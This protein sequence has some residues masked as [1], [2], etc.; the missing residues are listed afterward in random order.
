M[1]TLKTIISGGQTGADR[2]AL[3]AARQ[4][5][6]PHQGWCPAGRLS[7]DGPISQIYHLQETPSS[8]YPQRTEWNVR[9]SDAT[10]IFSYGQPMGGTRL[11]IKLA[12]KLRKPHLLINLNLPTHSNLKVI[13]H[14]LAA[15]NHPNLELNIAGSRESKCP[16][17]QQAVEHLLTSLI[18]Q[19][20]LLI[21]S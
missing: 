20:P 13:H 5:N 16:G 8:Q 11:T 3:N 4:L 15:L 6:L 17:I 10:L 2:G 18:R 12:Q 9:D 14:W 1:T 19:Y 7:E 21:H